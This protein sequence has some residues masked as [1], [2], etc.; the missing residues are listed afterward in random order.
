MLVP[1]LKPLV[2]ASMVIGE[3]PVMNSRS[4]PRPYPA[5]AFSVAKKLR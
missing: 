1:M 5:P 2:T 4:T 3:T